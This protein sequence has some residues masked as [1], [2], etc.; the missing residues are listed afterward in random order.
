MPYIS[1]PF[2]GKERD[3]EVPPWGLEPTALKGGQLTSYNYMFQG[4]KGLPAKPIRNHTSNR[5]DPQSWR[6]KSSYTEQFFT[7]Q[8][9]SRHQA[10][11]ASVNRNHRPHP[12]NIVWPMGPSKGYMIW[13]PSNAIPDKPY[14]APN[15]IR[16]FYENKWKTTTQTTY[17][18]YFNQDKTTKPSSRLNE[19]QSSTNGSRCDTRVQNSQCQERY[20]TPQLGTIYQSQFVGDNGRPSTN[21]QPIDYSWRNIKY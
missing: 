11:R 2:E 13:K 10:N 21:A 1:Q 4:L 14:T 16:N 3:N 8:M 15:L 7:P 12:Q 17:Q 5:F 9:Y 20:A 18:N 6:D 19:R